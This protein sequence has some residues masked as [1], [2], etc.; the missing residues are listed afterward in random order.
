MTKLVLKINY[1]LIGI[2]LLS[3]SIINFFEQNDSI[4]AIANIIFIIFICIF[5][6]CSIKITPL[7]M[8]AAIGLL[9]YYLKD[10]AHDWDT[11]TFEHGAQALIFYIVA[12]S[13]IPVFLLQVYALFCA[14]GKE[15]LKALLYIFLL[16]IVGVVMLFSWIESSANQFGILG[17]I[18]SI[19]APLLFTF[20]T[21]LAD[22]FFSVDLMK[23]N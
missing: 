6:A 11:V 13:F 7:S 12:A 3:L 14:Y 15:K 9:I 17:D 23:R 16:L 1:F 19:V 21:A 18:L 10:Y 2:T 5:I 20:I 4:N 8:I 22:K